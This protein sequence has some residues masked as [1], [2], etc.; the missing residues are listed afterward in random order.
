[1]KLL[2]LPTSNAARRDAQRARDVA[3]FDALCAARPLKPPPL[4]QLPRVASAAEL[5]LRADR[6]AGVVD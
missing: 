3:A 2:H 4:R 1:M 6:R 5:A